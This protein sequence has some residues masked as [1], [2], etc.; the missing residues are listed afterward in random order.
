MLCLLI[1]VRFVPLPEVGR[2]CMNRVR[3]HVQQCSEVG[4]LTP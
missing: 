4:K 3:L 1:H 2:T